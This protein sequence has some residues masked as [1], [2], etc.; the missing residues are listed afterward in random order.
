MKA[1]PAANLEMLQHM[2]DAIPFA[3]YTFDKDRKVIYANRASSFTQESAT[4]GAAIGAAEIDHFER[5]K[6]FDAEGN[7]LPDSDV[8]VIER[9]FLGEET[10][11]LILGH[12][13]LS[14]GTHKWIQITCL[15][16]MDEEG[17][18]SYGIL[19]YRDVSA[20]KNREDKLRFLLES[21]KILSI[22]MDFDERLQKKT[23]LAVPSLADWCSI[24][25][26]NR[27]GKIERQALVHRDPKKVEWILEYERKYPQKKGHESATQRVI[28]TGNAEF[29]KIIT[30]EMIDAVPDVSPEQRHDIESLRL[31][32]LMIL[33]IGRP[34]RVLGTLSV[35]YAESGRIYSDEDFSFFKEFAQHLSVLLDNARLYNEISMRDQSKDVFLASLS[36]ELRNPLAPIRSSLELLQLQNKDPNIVP[37]LEVIEHQ[38]D[39]MAHLL[40][41]L[42]D[43]TRFIRGKIQ[44]ELVPTDLM[45]VLRHV[46]RAL[47]KIAKEKDIT[48]SMAHNATEYSVCADRVRLEQAFTNLIGNALKFTP[49]GGSVSVKVETK[50]ENAIIQIRDTGAG[51]TDEEMR[52]IFEP[53]YQSE[54]V[55][56]GN[57]GLGIGLRLVYEILE[58]HHGSITVE[59]NG[60]DMGS[61]F[62]VS[63]PLVLATENENDTA[64]IDTSSTGTQRKIVI[65]D[66]NRAAA[67]A[68]SKLLT[69]LGWHTEA[70]YSGPDFLEYTQT[71]TPDLALLDIGMPDM[72]G[73]TVAQT[74]RA[75]GQTLPIIA[76]TGYGLD[77]D[78][79]KA[80]DAGFNAHL[81]KPASV[82]QLRS[83][84]EELIGAE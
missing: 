18:F 44:V 57:T 75:R 79:K 65:V 55:R 36:H 12:R 73:Y 16:V 68:M 82:V 20:R 26:V 23:A 34:G 78:K 39:H 62:T 52:H 2:V 50:G 22:T 19:M 83:V 11:D 81:I 80:F 43:A 31:S 24:E 71:S 74:L 40:N 10:R 58:L 70:F 61:T 1:T 13:N 21:T 42:L 30:Q 56:G 47:D 4:E 63:I 49:R 8:S 7:P 41:D 35:A 64:V 59:S 53:Y 6:Y 46:S 67:D 45:R 29:I 15:P 60:K 3:V 25:I 66:D 9:A 32:S 69:A 48:L 27:E 77:E 5:N 76:L 84:I 51:I 37:E 14:T 28:R 17:D 72:D 54:R 38:F 33:P